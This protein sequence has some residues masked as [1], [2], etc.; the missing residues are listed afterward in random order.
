MAKQ[1]TV[2]QKPKA[3]AVK[4]AKPGF[5]DKNALK[6]ALVFGVIAL[7]I[8]LYRIGYL[9]LWV[10]EYMHALAAIKGEFKHGENNGIILTWFNTLF[11]GIF[12]DNEFSMRFP[13]ALLGAALVPATYVLGNTIANKKVGLMSALLVTFSL[14][15]IFW[16][17]VDRP[18]GMV[19]T[20]YVPLVLSFWLMLE[21]P[22]KEG[23]ALA[24]FGIN[25]KFLA[26]TLLAFALSMLSQLICF[27][28]IFSAGFYGSLVA[29]DAWINKKFTPLKLNAYN[30]LFYLNVI[31]VVLMFTPFGNQLMRPIIEI[32]LP[33]NMATLILPDLK[34]AAAAFDTDKAY[35]SFDVYLG[36]INYDFKWVSILGWV[37]MIVAFLKNR[38]LSYILISGFAVPFFLMS[39]FF[40]E[41]CH[42]KY[43]SYIYPLFLISAAYALYYIAFVLGQMLSKTF[44]ETNK[45]YLTACTLV[46]CMFVL[47]ASKRKEIGSMLKTEVHG[48]VVDKA[49]SEIHFVNWKQP[50]EFIKKNLKKGDVVMATVQFAPK[51]YLGMDSVV[52]FR[53]MH[54]DAKKKDYVSNTPDQRKLS[55]TTYEQLVKTYNENPR[56]W[57]LAD[58]YFDNALTDPRAKQFVE[59]NFTY[60]FDA[61]D[62]GGVKVFSWDKA[63]P[64]SYQSAFV[65]EMG[66]NANQVASMPF[67]MT[68]NKATLP[69][70]A[71]M[72]FLSQGIDSDN[73]A[74]VIINGNQVAI[75]ANGKASQIEGNMVEVPTTYFVDGDNKIQFAYNGEEGNGDVIKG[76][77]IYNFDLR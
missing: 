72:F 38:K 32:F 13:V 29:I 26:F 36:V 69:P 49:I 40:R 63:K 67:T 58:Y 33:G 74:Y 11:A 24:S 44:S 27:L 12:G 65:I 60:H 3:A 23:S 46:F 15:F 5:I 59:Q 9:S 57:L 25:P 39:F 34:A 8:R 43:L 2:A 73:E 55:A 19:A 51:F 28:F 37:G 75:K 17:R 18:Y 4:V 7:F 77:V 61:C 31:A 54:Y 48:N 53:Q 22:A 70:K 41:P 76:C 71:Y 62:D 14:Y 64:K 21:K 50:S 30:V 52:W 20:F 68:V 16:S 56:G 42:A 45:T 10:D 47:G 6:I 35:K 66:K 1:T